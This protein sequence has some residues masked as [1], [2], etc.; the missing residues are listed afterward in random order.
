MMVYEGNPKHKHPWQQG[1]KGSLC[2][3]SISIHPKE[4]L[5]HS[6]LGPDGKRYATCDG[7]CFCAQESQRCWHGYPVGWREVPE[8]LW[9]AWKNEGKIQKS[10]ISKHW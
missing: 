2:P 8:K 7:Q 3:K 10:D 1:K 6:I 9:R 4:L 5:E